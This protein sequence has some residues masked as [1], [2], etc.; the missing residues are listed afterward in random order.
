MI[1]VDPSKCS[2]C[3]RCEVNC[4]F[5]HTGMVGRR[6]AR[7]RVVKIEEIGIDFP[8]VC[9]QC[10]ERYCTKCPEHAIEVGPLGQIII[11]PTLCVSCGTCET[12]CPIGAIEL[13]EDIPYVCDLCGGDPRCVKAC[14]LGAIYY[15][16]DAHGQISLRSFK[17]KTKKMSPGQKRLIFALE[18]SRPL[19]EKWVSARR[20]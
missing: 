9:Q 11:S 18:S 7:I 20:K 4:S 16:P 12:L 15:E 10:V 8:V 19:R 14:T 6:S 3:V 1:R 2:G 17:A 13:Y 5:F